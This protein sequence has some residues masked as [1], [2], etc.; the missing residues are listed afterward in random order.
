[1]VVVVGWLG[2]ASTT[3][4][5]THHVSHVGSRD[6]SVFFSFVF[7]CVFRYLTVWKC[8]RQLGEDAPV[9]IL[10]FALGKPIVLVSL[11]AL[12][13]RWEFRVLCLGETGG[14]S[15][16]GFALYTGRRF[17]QVPVGLGTGNFQG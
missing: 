8:V 11:L 5:C 12:L 4:H 3:L 1:M 15:E 7:P 13:T 16:R 14:E 6:T 10:S 17:D 9:R 2:R